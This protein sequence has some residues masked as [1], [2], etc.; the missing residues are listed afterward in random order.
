MAITSGFTASLSDEV[1]IDSYFDQIDVGGSGTASNIQ[2]QSTDKVV[3]T[4]V[5]VDQPGDIVF[6]NQFGDPQFL[7]EVPAGL[8]PMSATRILSSA[9]VR[10]ISR[11]TTASLLS[12]L[13][14]YRY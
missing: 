10:G 6:E 12:W 14:D 13:G 2:S 9:I 7:K 3:S 11:A 5:L 4:Y 1:V 8:I